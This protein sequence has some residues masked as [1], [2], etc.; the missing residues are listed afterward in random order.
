MSRQRW[1]RHRPLFSSQTPQQ[2]AKQEWHVLPGL[3]TAMLRVCT[4][5]GA[6]VLVMFLIFAYTASRIEG[7]QSTSLP[8]KMVL[9]LRLDE[10]P[11]EIPQPASL[12]DPFAAPALTV[13]DIVNVID[14][15]ATDD[16]VKGMVAHLE[17]GTYELVRSQEI[18]NAVKRFRDTGKFSYIYSSSYGQGSGDTGR[19]YLASAFGEIWMQPMGLVSIAGVRADTP[20]ARKALDMIGVEPQFFQ[21]KEYKTAYESFT[22]SKMSEPN[23][24]ETKAMIDDIKTQLLTEIPADRGIKPSAFENLVDKGLFTAPEALE[25]KLVTKLDYLDVLSDKIKMDVTGRVDEND[26]IFVDAATY[27]ADVAWETGE[28]NIMMS[29]FGGKPNVALIYV[30]GMILDTNVSGD[31]GVAAADEIAPAINDAADDETI[32]AIVIRVDSPGG[33]PAA[34][35]DILRAIERAKQKGKPVIVSMGPTAASGGYW[36]SAYADQIFAGPLTLTGSIGVLGGKV[37]VGKLWD[38]IGVNWDKSIQWGKNSGM[39][40]LNTPFSKSEAERIDAMLDNVYAAFTA[41]VAKGR[42]MTQEQVDKIAGGRVW[43]GMRAVKIGLVDQL[44]GLREAMDYT[45][46]ILGAKDKNDLNVIVLPEPKSTLERLLSV[47]DQGQ[48]TSGMKFQQKIYSYL[49]PMIDTMRVF[50][51][52]HGVAAYETLRIQ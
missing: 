51:G 7:V 40:S 36:V 26:E 45:A 9:Y 52:G 10:D 2:P 19:Y 37:S 29:S 50:D 38:K 43:T 48:V 22:N 14:R 27:A 25:S 32:E 8:G 13:H 44:G 42:G 46:Q 6:F 16:R 33:T 3:W 39:W 23:R 34:S 5:L 11:G 15:S 24:E 1:N 21:R 18:R 28:R 30:V 4:V 20:F 31:Y 17:T 49:S 35:D 41:R 47:V 12:T